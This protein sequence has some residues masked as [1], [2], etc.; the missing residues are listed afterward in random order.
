L[1]FR[2]VQSMSARIRELSAEVAQ[3]RIKATKIGADEL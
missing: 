1:A 3:L 2:L